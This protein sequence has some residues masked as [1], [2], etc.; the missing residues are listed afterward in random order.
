MQLLKPN[1]PLSPIETAL[2]IPLLVVL[3]LSGYILYT[4]FT[5]PVIPEKIWGV[6]SQ[7]ELEV[8]NL[9]KSDAE[10]KKNNFDLIQSVARDSSGILDISNC[11]PQPLVL[12]V[13]LGDQ[14]ELRNKTM[15][16]TS[17]EVDNEHTYTVNAGNRLTIPAD[18]GH[19][20]GIYSYTCKNGK[21]NPIDGIIFVTQ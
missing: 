16:D 19:G 11:I 8:V 14:I 3:V 4:H 13:R 7:K 2:I 5:T 18:F 20:H 21:A 6:Y 10:A 17:I 1:L 9:P 15:F 12:K